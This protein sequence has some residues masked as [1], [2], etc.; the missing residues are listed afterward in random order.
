M[1]M[2]F[3]LT[4]GIT[5]VVLLTALLVC[6]LMPDT[7][8]YGEQ[9]EDT[10]ERVSPEPATRYE[11]GE[12]DNIRIYE[13]YNQAVVNITSIDLSYNWYLEPVPREQGTGSGSIIDHQGHI[14]TNFHVIQNADKLKVTLYDGTVLDARVVGVDKHNDLAVI[15]VP[16]EEQLAAITLGTSHDLKVG[17]KVLAIG[18]PFGLSRTLTTG[19]VSAV[20]RPIV[21]SSGLVIREM[22]QTDASINPGNSGGPLLNS[23][24]EMIGINTMIY[25]QSGGSIGIGFA[26]PVDTAKRII[27]DL[28]RYGQVNRGWLNIT[29]MPLTYE[30]VRYE[31]LPIKAGVLVIQVPPGSPADKAGLRGGDPDRA[32]RYRGYRLYLGG[33]VIVEL[34][35]MSVSSFANVLDA[36]EDNKPGEVVTVK[37][38]RDGRYLE[39]EVPLSQRPDDLSW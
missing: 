12:A 23:R 10:R 11:S 15:K 5:L 37:L 28:I 21:T 9:A 18:N 24:G 13:Q 32:V 6:D 1:K 17:Q 8:G 35:G 30:I 22:I 14:L 3:L 29:F 36:L 39:L 7:W 20:G 4:A 38:W 19:I 33:D 27:P 25:S 26:V 16:A 2:N 31:R 34:D